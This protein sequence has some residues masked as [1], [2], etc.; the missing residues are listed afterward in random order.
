MGVFYGVLG[1]FL[2]TLVW[3]SAWRIGSGVIVILISLELKRALQYVH[4]IF[5]HIVIIQM[6]QQ[7]YWKKERW[8]C[9]RAPLFLPGAV[10]LNLHSLRRGKRIGLI[11]FADQTDRVSWRKLCYLLRQCLLS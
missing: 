5:G 8:H 2:F 7:I 11:L 4:T 1:Y 10:L 6:T 9:Y 3:N